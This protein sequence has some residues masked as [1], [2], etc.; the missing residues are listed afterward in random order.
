MPIDAMLN[1]ITTHYR[2]QGLNNVF[3]ILGSL[4]IIG[5]PSQII[6]DFSGGFKAISDPRSS[7]STQILGGAGV[8]AKSTIGG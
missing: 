4:N 3:S 5:N 8:I 1:D 2:E 6:R 7:N